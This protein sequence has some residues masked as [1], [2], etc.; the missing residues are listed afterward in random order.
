METAPSFASTKTN[1]NRIRRWTK[2]HL[3]TQILTRDENKEKKTLTLH[4]LDNNFFG[5]NAER[6]TSLISSD[7]LN[8][9]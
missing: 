2:L 4:S 6:K 5:E 9:Q 7:E 1:Q 8:Q 3:S